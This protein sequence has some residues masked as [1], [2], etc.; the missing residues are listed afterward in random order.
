M[1]INP[2]QPGGRTQ[3]NPPYA[4]LKGNYCT[5]S[6]TQLFLRFIQNPILGFLP[7]FMFT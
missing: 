4:P 7:G 6:S 3:K 1:K 5:V 2:P